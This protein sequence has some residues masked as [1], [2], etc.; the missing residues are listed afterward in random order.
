MQQVT[1]GDHSLTIE[2]QDCQEIML[3]V[4]WLKRDVRLRD[5]GPLSHALK[6]SVPFIFLYVYESDQLK[7]HSVHGSHIQFNNEGLRDFVARV[8]SPL[9]L[10]YDA[11]RSQN[12]STDDKCNVLVT[13]VGLVCDILAEIN[14]HHKIKQLLSHEEPGH[15]TSFIRDKQVLQWC[16]QNGVMWSEFNQSGVIRGLHSRAEL[17]H[18][19]GTTINLNHPIET[20]KR[21]SRRG[22]FAFDDRSRQPNHRA[23]NTET[24]GTSTT[25]ISIQGIVSTDVNASHRESQPIPAL[26]TVQTQK[27]PLKRTKSQ[28]QAQA[29]AQSDSSRGTS[30][31]S[32]WQRFMN[33]PE[34]ASDVIND[35][36]L[37]LAFR[38]KIFLSIKSEGILSP[39]ELI[40]VEDK[41]TPLFDYL[42]VFRMCVSSSVRQFSSFYNTVSPYMASVLVIL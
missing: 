1:T 2:V 9:Q 18:L 17:E 15:N 8:G 11:S 23:Q 42:A 36:T 29:Q 16:Q 5:H 41:L 6:D 21:T 35:E 31:S 24:A 12:E 33:S 27:Q 28:S 20:T 38:R 22:Q 3:N 25:T 13:R 37:R 39:E 40:Q 32:I 14:Q 26:P 30:W 34:Y 4:V 19:R 7:H 10:S